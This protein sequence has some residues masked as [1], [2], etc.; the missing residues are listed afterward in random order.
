MSLS[1]GI[2]RRRCHLPP[3][4]ARVSVMDTKQRRPEAQRPAI[5]T[6]RLQAMLLCS[7]PQHT[8]PSLLPSLSSVLFSR[9]LR[10]PPPYLPSLWLEIKDFSRSRGLSRVF[11]LMSSRLGDNQIFMPEQ[12]TRLFP[13]SRAVGE[14]RCARRL[15]LA[16]HQPAAT[17]R[18]L[19]II[20]AARASLRGAAA[21]LTLLKFTGASASFISWHFYFGWIILYHIFSF[22]SVFRM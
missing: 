19:A 1:P 9:L 10:L 12:R 22:H 18:S 21:S 17:K 3:G 20:C 4:P 11:T 16:L 14:R 5:V 6:P 2:S 13:A 8:T 7:R 15:G